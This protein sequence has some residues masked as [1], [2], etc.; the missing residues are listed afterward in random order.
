VQASQPAR[1]QTL[2]GRPK[3]EGLVV[4]KGKAGAQRAHARSTFLVVA[5]Q[6]GQEDGDGNE[7]EEDGLRDDN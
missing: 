3:A 6:A 5:A 2:E 7:E 1:L 4:I